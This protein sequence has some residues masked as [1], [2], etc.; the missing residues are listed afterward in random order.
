MKIGDRV[1]VQRA[2]RLYGPTHNGRA[3]TIVR[4]HFAGWYVHLD[5]LPRERVAKVELFGFG[6][7]VQA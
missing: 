3:G 2:P 5:P 1:V 4:G 6:D 7:L